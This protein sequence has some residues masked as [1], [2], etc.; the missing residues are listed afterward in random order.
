[1]F[2]TRFSDLSDS[3]LHR[4]NAVC[5][6]FENAL[7][8]DQSAS[9]EDH[10]RAAPDEIRGPLFCELL[11]IE[12]ELR[13]TVKGNP[14]QTHYEIRFPDRKDVIRTVFDRVFG[15]PSVTQAPRPATE[16]KTPVPGNGDPDFDWP[17]RIGRYRIDSLLGKGGCGLVYKAHDG[18]LD[19]EVAIKVPHAELV[20]RPEDAETYRAEARTVAS[21]D[22]ASIVPVYDIGSNPDFPCFVVSKF[23][24][25]TNLASL[26]KRDRLHHRR[27]AELT[28]L[29]EAIL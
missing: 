24:D 28:A 11:A 22:H 16:R 15:N 6:A 13:S 8:H 1:M 17:S 19:R 7:M 3:E 2:P 9:I 5:E 21:L 27:A 20:L 10:L 14:D 23:I 12:L 26:L 18:D 29:L 25:G 4:V